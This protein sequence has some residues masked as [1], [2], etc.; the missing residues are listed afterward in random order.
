MLEVGADVGVAVAPVC[1]PLGPERRRALVVEVAQTLELVECLPALVVVEAAPFEASVE[2]DPRAVGCA[3]RSERD[4]QG[5]RP[6]G[7][8]EGGRR[9]GRRPARPAEPP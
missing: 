4:L 6:A 2:L 7:W 5:V 8:A 3:E 1:E 9:A